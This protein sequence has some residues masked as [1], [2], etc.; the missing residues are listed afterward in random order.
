MNKHI[1]KT[2]LYLHTISIHMFQPS[3]GHPQG[4][5]LIQRS[6]KVNKMMKNSP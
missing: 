2:P 1:F 3:K 6:S 4:V 5:R